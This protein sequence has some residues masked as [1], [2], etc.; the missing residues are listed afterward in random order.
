MKKGLS[1][2]LLCISL[3]AFTSYAGA[4]Q[5]GT[6]QTASVMAVS[7]GDAVNI[8]RMNLSPEGSPQAGVP[9]NVTVNAYCASGRQIN[10]QYYY[11]ANYGTDAYASTEWTL[12]KDY[13]TE[14]S[15]QYVF[16]QAGNYVMVVRAVTDPANEPAALPIIGQAVSVSENNLINIKGLS[17]STAS[18]KAGENVTFTAQA[19]TVTGS[20]A[21]YEFYYCGNYGT[22]GYLTTA[23]TKVKEYSTANSCAYN[24]PTAGN[25]VV[26]VRA[27]AD[28]NQEPVALPIIGTAVSV[29]ER[30]GTPPS[31]DMND[32]EWEITTT[33]SGIPGMPPQTT[34]GRQ[35]LTEDDYI[36]EQE[37]PDSGED[38]CTDVETVINGN[39]VSW[40]IICN[41]E[42]CG[43]TT[44]SG[45]MTYS[46]DTF[47]GSATV[48]SSGGNCNYSMEM[49][50]HRIG[51]CN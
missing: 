9:L 42:D 6:G 40:T 17:S 31:F 43:Q 19:A 21:Y 29:G 45:T 49:T 10:Y 15:A 20:P 34:T 44:S 48:T 11:C 36:P 38:N 28:K 23:W 13:S 25:Y 50:G 37:D 35:C 2:F 8:T 14:N 3:M 12:V 26:V 1:G 39:T 7:A 32:G 16:P 27:V 47:S 46:G 24:F 5:G 30:Q 51:P 4:E 41:D 33:L 22:P 18:P